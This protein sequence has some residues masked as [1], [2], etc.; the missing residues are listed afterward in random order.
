VIRRH[1]DIKLLR[2]ASDTATLSQTQ[3]RL[4]DSLWPALR[5]GGTL[6]YATCSVLPAENDAV[7]GA[8]LTRTVDAAG[9]PLRA[10]T[11]WGVATAH[12]RQVFP[13][14]D[15]SDGFYYAYIGKRD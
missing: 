14:G 10:S 4:L 15:A 5:P 8:F 2:R 9:L 3:Q 6:L 7:V 13:G 1:P 12:G 11:D